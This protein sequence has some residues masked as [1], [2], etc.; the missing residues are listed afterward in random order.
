MMSESPA[1]KKKNN[2]IEKGLQR[3]AKTWQSNFN[4]QLYGTRQLTQ[5]QHTSVDDAQHTGGEELPASSPK[6]NA[7]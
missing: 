3:R 4:L 6:I 5:M 2:A 1:V 7:V